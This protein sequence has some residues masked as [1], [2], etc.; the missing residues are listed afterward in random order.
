MANA[1]TLAQRLAALRD[2]AKAANCDYKKAPFF[3][4]LAAFW[5]QFMTHDWFSHLQE[6]HNTSEMMAM[7]CKSQKVNGVE[8][9]L[10]PQDVQKLNC[11]PGDKMERAYIA[12]SGEPQTFSYKGK[13]Y[14]SRAYKT[15]RNTVTAW[16]DASQIYGYDAISRQRVKRDPKDKAKLLLVPVGNRQG[17][18]EKYGYLPVVTEC[19]GAGGDAKCV[20]DP[21][22]PAWAGQEATAFPDNWNIGLSFYHNLF[23]REHNLF[24]DEFRKLTAKTPNADSGLRNPS[25]PDQ[26][27]RYRDVSDGELSEAAR[28]VIA[29]EIAKIHTIEWTTQLLYGEPLYLGMSSNWF[30]LF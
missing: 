27:I 3:N 12:E 14:L 1:D 15:T 5:I 6:G 2:C 30:G 21:I 9:T 11:R 20:A 24:V 18:G 10:T 17:T 7:G 4:V 29:A 25:Q 23:A 13:D 22:H 8:T 26:V 19:P 28:L 16:W